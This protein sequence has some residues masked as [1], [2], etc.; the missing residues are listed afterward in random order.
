MIRSLTNNDIPY[1]T[2]LAIKE[3]FAPGLGDVN[4]YRNTDKQGLWVG[5]LNSKVIGCI[6]GIKYNQNYGFVEEI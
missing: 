3:N 5:C 1:I 6:A 2:K 4:I